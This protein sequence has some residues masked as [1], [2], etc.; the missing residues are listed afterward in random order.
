MK[1]G[2][3]EKFN[4]STQNKESGGAFEITFNQAHQINYWDTFA[5]VCAELNADVK[6]AS[7]VDYEYAFDTFSNMLEDATKNEQSLFIW[8]N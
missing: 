2:F 1:H 3:S 8:L 7:D 5:L 6:N 4:F